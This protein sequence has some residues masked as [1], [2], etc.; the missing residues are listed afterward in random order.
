MRERVGSILAK[1]ET[2]RDG[3]LGTIRA[4]EHRIELDPAA[5]LVDHAPHRTGFRKRDFITQ[6]ISKMLK[7]KVIQTS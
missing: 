6:E 2:M 5:T 1:D 7:L 3:T 4:T